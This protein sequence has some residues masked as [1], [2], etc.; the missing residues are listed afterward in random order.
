ML[1][2]I[3][4]RISPL[5]KEQKEK[6][7]TEFNA[8]NILYVLRIWDKEVTLH[9]R[10]LADMLNPNGYHGYGNKFLELFVNRLSESGCACKINSEDDICVIDE[11]GIDGQ[12]RL[13]IYIS[14]KKKNTIIIENKIYASDQPNQILDYFTFG[15]KEATFLLLYLTL[16]GTEPNISSKG[17][18]KSKEHFFCISYRDFIIPWL[19]KCEEYIKEFR[20][21]LPETPKSIAFKIALE[22][23]KQTVTYMTRDNSGFMHKL[24][25]QIGDESQFDL[26]KDL[27]KN[28]NRL[29]QTLSDEF[30]K[31]LSIR[32]NG[33]IYNNSQS[34]PIWIEMNTDQKSSGIK[35]WFKI[36]ISNNRIYCA[37]MVYENQASG[38]NGINDER[39]TAFINTVSEF[40]KIEEITKSD[41]QCWWWATGLDFN[42]ENL[43]I[44]LVKSILNKESDL[45]A[46][47][48][49]IHLIELIANRTGNP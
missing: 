14:D 49:L 20:I 33:S 28:I 42:M 39:V 5:L 16:F 47:T 35:D 46:F 4:N 11:K 7:E 2:N 21:S 1:E 18:L 40:V 15:K 9:S 10:F 41:S 17:E 23:Y 13:D 48:E 19:D 30:F 43:N 31:K 29:P 36:D 25:D 3:I 34:F 45:T 27:N 8:Y 38:F 22:Q 12:K 6:E 32:I 26:I 37:F 24:M 44:E